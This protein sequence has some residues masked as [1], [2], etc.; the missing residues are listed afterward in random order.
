MPVE[1]DAER[2][3][4]VDPDEHGVEAFYARP[5]DAAIG[6]NVIFDAPARQSQAMDGSV[7]TVVAYPRALCVAGDL[8]QGAREG[9]SLEIPDP[10]PGAGRYTVKAV[11]ADST[12]FAR[13]DLEG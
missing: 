1:D 12:G 11:V 3:A 4:F 2:S 13:L 5:G 7:G 6:I 9:D 10:H 8:P